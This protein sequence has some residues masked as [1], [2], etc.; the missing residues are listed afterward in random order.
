MKRVKS[1]RIEMMDDGGATCTIC[2]ERDKQDDLGKGSSIY[3][4]SNE[5]KT[6]HP[7]VSHLIKHLSGHLKRHA[8]NAKEY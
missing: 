5:L 7:N 6:A 4:D 1:A 3:D 2:H 8:I